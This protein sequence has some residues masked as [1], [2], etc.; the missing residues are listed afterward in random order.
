MVLNGNGRAGAAAAAADRVKAQG[1]H[2]RQRRQRGGDHAAHA[3]HVPPGYG[4]EASRLGR[5]LRIRVVRPLDGMS[6]RQLLGAHLVLILG[7]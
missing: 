6:P 7:K 3:D 1:L 4:A 2:R 5:D